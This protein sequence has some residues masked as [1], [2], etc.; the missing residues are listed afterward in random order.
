MIVKTI[1]CAGCNS[2]PIFSTKHAYV[3][4]TFL[5]SLYSQ[6]KRLFLSSGRWTCDMCGMCASCLRRSPGEGN[7]SRWKHE[8]CSSTS[9]FSLQCRNTVNLLSQEVTRKKMTYE[10]RRSTHMKINH[11]QRTSFPLH[12]TFMHEILVP[13]NLNSYNFF[14]SYGGIGRGVVPAPGRSLRSS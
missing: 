10:Y 13:L 1:F 3:S 4:N 14:T 2:L 9:I 8:V 12:S 7:T 5:F 6:T 11:L